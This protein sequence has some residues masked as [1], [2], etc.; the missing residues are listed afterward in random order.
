MGIFIGKGFK[1]TK[2][3]EINKV[4]SGVEDD[5]SGVEL[6]TDLLSDGVDMD[7]YE[8]E[9]SSSEVI[10]EE[11]NDELNSDVNDSLFLGEGDNDEYTLPYIS[12][13]DDIDEEDKK[14]EERIKKLGF[15]CIDSHSDLKQHIHPWIFVDVDGVKEEI[16]AEIGITWDC[17]S[18]MH[19]H[20]NSGKIHIETISEEKHF[21]FNDWM[22]L[23]NKSLKREGY[24]NFFYVNGERVKEGELLKYAFKDGDVIYLDYESFS[25]I[26]RS[27]ISKF[28][29]WFSN[30]KS[31]LFNKF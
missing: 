18:E 20:A 30:K 25:Y 17:M 27:R 21:V 3:V 9:E 11:I 2:N 4:E 19:T 6:E 1:E 14:E 15:A 10:G 28:I 5:V 29:G 7:G 24:F 23:W 26:W 12:N 8:S 16:P 13:F 22:N 31:Q